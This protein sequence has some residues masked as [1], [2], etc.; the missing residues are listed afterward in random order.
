MDK[1]ILVRNWEKEH[2]NLFCIKWLF[3]SSFVGN[4]RKE[5][6]IKVALTTRQVFIKSWPSQVQ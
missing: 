5:E 6:R 4:I 2:S 1:Q 3:S